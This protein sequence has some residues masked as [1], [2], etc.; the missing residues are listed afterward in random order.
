MNKI[1]LK[2]KSAVFILI[3]IVF[4]LV[5]VGCNKTED[6]Y[7]LIIDGEKISRGEFMVYLMEQKKSF[8][9]TG[10]EDIWGADFDGVSA[11]E[12]AK[13]NAA[14]SVQMVK[15]AVKQTKALGID[16]TDIDQDAVNSDSEV[17][18]NDMISRLGEDK[19]K[20]LKIDENLI[21]K[22]IKEGYIQTKVFDYVTEGYQVNESDFDKYVN[23]YYS[24]NKLQYSTYTV[25][26]ISISN[27]SG[28]SGASAVSRANEAL[29]KLESGANFDA[30]AKE[31]SENSNLTDFELDKSTLTDEA[32]QK[33]YET[34]KGDYFMVEDPVSYY[35]IYLVVE[36]EQTPLDEIKDEI[37]VSY[38]KD[39]KQEIYQTQNDKW[40]TEIT[41]D[42]N[43]DVWDNISI[44][45]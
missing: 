43:L 2:I 10:G 3:T 11:E 14:N 12:V 33:L 17:L 15:T 20:E 26:E 4:A 25:K 44:V 45:P 28:D 22:I 27:Y 36:I 7:V 32:L 34:N 35:H 38:I 21:K 24:Q 31:Y 29:S 23:D 19:L 9:Q 13:Q 8:E 40:N 5:C 41:V 37:R 39:K 16:T 18:Y 1:K 42:K 30:V 6:D